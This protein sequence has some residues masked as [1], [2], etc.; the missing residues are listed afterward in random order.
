MY[1]EFEMLFWAVESFLMEGDFLWALLPT[2]GTQYRPAKEEREGTVAA[3]S[4]KNGSMMKM[5]N[6]ASH[7]LL[8]RSLA[9]WPS[10]PC[11]SAQCTPFSLLHHL[12]PFRCRSHRH[13]PWRQHH[14]VPVADPQLQSRQ[15]TQ[16]PIHHTNRA[17]AMSYQSAGF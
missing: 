17:I 8:L 5:K 16:D 14:W 13:F 11:C 9:V 6:W 3:F 4:S 10:D 2:D 7:L 12:W 1:W 15:S